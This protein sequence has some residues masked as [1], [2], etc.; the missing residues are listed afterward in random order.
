MLNDTLND[1]SAVLALNDC[2]W[3]MAW[4]FLALILFLPLG[5]KRRSVA[6]QVMSASD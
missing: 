4:T 6:Q 2:F 3:V 1:Q 5:F